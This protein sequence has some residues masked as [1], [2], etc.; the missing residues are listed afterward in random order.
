VNLRKLVKMR[1][2]LD[3]DGYFDRLLSGDSWR[4]WRALLIAIVGEALTEDERAIFKAI[5][6]RDN[7][8]LEPVEEFWAAKRAP[9]PPW[10]LIWRPASTI[11][12]SWRQA[13]AA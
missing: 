5:T 9:R 13:S 1:E 8:P 11:A 2:A 7:E 6:G 10:R 12:R 3:S 4:S